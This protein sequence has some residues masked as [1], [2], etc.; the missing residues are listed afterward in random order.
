MSRRYRSW[1]NVPGYWRTHHGELVP[2]KPRF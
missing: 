1:E 2:L